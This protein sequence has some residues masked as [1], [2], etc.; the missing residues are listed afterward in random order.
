MTAQ[1]TLRRP[2]R[3]GRG[4]PCPVFRPSR[5]RGMERREA[6]GR[7]A[8]APLGPALRSA[9]PA[10]RRGWVCEAHPEARAPHA[11]GLRRPPPR[12]CASRRSTAAP[13]MG[14]A[15]PRPPSDPPHEC[16]ASASQDA[17][18][19]REVFRA[20]ITYFL[21]SFSP[22]LGERERPNDT[23][24]PAGEMPEAAV[25][26]CSVASD[27]AAG[28]S[29][30]CHPGRAKREPGSITATT[31]LRKCRVTGSRL[32]RRCATLG[33]DDESVRTA[34]THPAPAGRSAAAA[35]R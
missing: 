31:S 13:D 30:S 20:G 32:A 25:G 29:G 23:R 26:R 28:S 16:G 9:S 19:V 22:R 12:R 6:P 15:A 18:S 8:T 17:R 3:R 21:F 33:R 11:A 35:R 27:G 24:P 34:T 14:G 10:R 1:P 2:F 7:C 4:L 5:K